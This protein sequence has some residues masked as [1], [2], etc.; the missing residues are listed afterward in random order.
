MPLHYDD[1]EKRLWRRGSHV[2]RVRRQCHRPRRTDAGPWGAREIM[3][4]AG[5]HASQGTQK[6]R[7]QRLQRG[8]PDRETGI[9][10]ACVCMQRRCAC[11]EMRLRAVR[12]LSTQL[13]VTQAKEKLLSTA[14]RCRLQRLP[15]VRMVGELGNGEFRAKSGGVAACASTDECKRRVNISDFGCT[16]VEK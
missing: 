14:M 3:C 9:L 16:A 15:R 7:Q 12:P 6:N 8:V 4:S 5:C 11:G 10:L 1:R 2:C 13:S